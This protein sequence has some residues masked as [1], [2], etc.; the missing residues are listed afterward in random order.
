[1]K[2]NRF[3]YV[4]A[5]ALATAASLA[6][7]APLQGC[8]TL[9]DDFFDKEYTKQ[10]RQ[11]LMSRDPDLEVG[12]VRCE[13][14]LDWSFAANKGFDTSKL[15][16]RFT[17][18][19]PIT[20]KDTLKALSGNPYWDLISL[21]SVIAGD[22]TKSAF[23]L[24]ILIADPKGRLRSELFKLGYDQ[25]TIDDLIHNVNIKNDKFCEGWIRH[26]VPEK[27]HSSEDWIKHQNS[28]RTPVMCPLGDEGCPDSPV[29]TGGG[30]TTSGSGGS[31][32][33]QY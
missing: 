19:E 29:T 22:L 20:A 30:T 16:K 31:G 33:D 18:S 27:F 28:P 1:M 13:G 11:W 10:L 8:G 2:N 21:F 17:A 9:V 23:R 15:P 4:T 26:V 12:D 5:A 6:V 14:S 3:A 32:G 24:T 7:T 25:E